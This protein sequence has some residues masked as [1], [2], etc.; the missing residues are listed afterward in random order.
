MKV[1]V[2]IARLSIGAMVVAILTLGEP[3]TAIRLAVSSTNSSHW[4]DKNNDAVLLAQTQ[5]SSSSQ[6]LG[7]LAGA[8]GGG[9]GDAG[10]GDDDK[11]TEQNCAPNINIIDNARQMIDPRSPLPP[12]NIEVGG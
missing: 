1:S 10:G 7:A 12:I 8:V 5:A 11:G 4:L 3:A 9:G 6:M 2:Y